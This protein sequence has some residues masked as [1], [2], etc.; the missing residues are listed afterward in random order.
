MALDP[1]PADGDFRTGAVR[2]SG[3]HGRDARFSL[4]TRW[5]SSTVVVRPGH[6]IARLL[7]GHVSQRP[8]HSEVAVLV[9][10]LGVM[11][12]ANLRPG[13]VPRI[14]PPPGPLGAHLDRAR[15]TDPIERVP[16]PTAGSPASGYCRERPAGPH[17]ERSGE[18][19]RR[20]PRSAEAERGPVGPGPARRVASMTAILLRDRYARGHPARSRAMERLREACARAWTRCCGG[21]PAAAS[22]TCSRIWACAVLCRADH[23]LFTHVDTHVRRGIVPGLHQSRRSDGAVVFRVAQEL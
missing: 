1:H 15:S 18:Q 12:L 6:S 16:V 21:G 19:Q 22:R 4:T 10:G 17:R 11:I 5:S 14:P 8:L 7:T 2:E 20:C 9:V 23:D 13:P 3:R